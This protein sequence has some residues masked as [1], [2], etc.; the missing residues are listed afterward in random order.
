MNTAKS[1]LTESAEKL[2]GE[3]RS[4]HS[5]LTRKLSSWYLEDCDGC[6]C[7]GYTVAQWNIG[8][9]LKLRMKE[10][11][12]DEA[13]AKDASS[14]RIIAD[15]APDVGKQKCC[16]A[17]KQVTRDRGQEAYSQTQGSRRTQTQ[18]LKE[19][20]NGDQQ[21]VLNKR[22]FP[23]G[24]KASSDINPNDVFQAD[25]NRIDSITSTKLYMGV[26]SNTAEDPILRQTKTEEV[27]RLANERA[28]SEQMQG[29]LRSIE[30]AE[31]DVMSRARQEVA[32]TEAEVKKRAEGGETETNS[33]VRT[34]ERAT[35]D[36]GAS[37]EG[38][39]VSSSVA[40]TTEPRPRRVTPTA[41]SAGGAAVG[42]GAGAGA[43]VAGDRARSESTVATAA[44]VDTITASAALATHE[45]VAPVPALVAAC[46]VKG[47]RRTSCSTEA[48][49]KTAMTSKPCAALSLTA[50]AAS[51]GKTLRR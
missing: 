23:T 10:D 37:V 18:K 5:V 48:A 47:P 25:A 24:P 29:L 21:I 42:A 7:T 31:F 9:P 13:D 3:A 11:M 28:L 12:S 49:L 15:T 45:R 46:A 17:E 20:L 51:L 36:Y 27:A 40:T 32:L 43:R 22:C 8:E 14:D 34:T 16:P 38:N 6:T 26:R 4:D 39:T 30:A 35:M 44:P 50:S 33:D 1:T 41:A 19:N 2:D